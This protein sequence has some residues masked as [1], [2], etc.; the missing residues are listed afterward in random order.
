[1]EEV[2]AEGPAPVEPTV[3]AVPAV[4]QERPAPSPAEPAATEKP[5]V[6]QPQTVQPKSQQVD[7]EPVAATVQPQP[8]IPTTSKTA[9][10]DHPVAWQLFMGQ[11]WDKYQSWHSRQPEQVRLVEPEGLPAAVADLPAE[12]QGMVVANPELMEGYVRFAAARGADLEQ[13][14]GEALSRASSNLT[15]GRERSE[16]VAQRANQ[17][18][19]RGDRSR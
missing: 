3:E 2:Q 1:M 19:A 6:R 18:P 7:P 5:Q 13:T 15:R 12:T 14:V 11:R 17:G 9:L 10:V 16:F 8:T 4:T